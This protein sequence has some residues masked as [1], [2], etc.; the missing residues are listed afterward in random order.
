[1]A[2]SLGK[3][4]VIVVNENEWADLLSLECPSQRLT[5]FALAHSG[6]VAKWAASG[7]WNNCA[8]ENESCNRQQ[9]VPSAASDK[10]VEHGVTRLWRHRRQLGNYSVVGVTSPVHQQP[11]KLV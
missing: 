7:D 9:K 3:L 10:R 11:P 1:M 5:E 4:G 6:R 2:G 8:I